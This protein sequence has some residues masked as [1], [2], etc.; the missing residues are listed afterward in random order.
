[1][2]LSIS[3]GE[4]LHLLI[5]STA[6]VGSPTAETEPSESSHPPAFIISYFSFIS[7]KYF[8]SEKGCRK[9][10][11]TEYPLGMPGCFKSFQS[12]FSTAFRIAGTI[13]DR[14]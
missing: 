1:M 10:K 2:S 12:S 7:M 13:S 11:M 8:F 9:M 4:S 3:Q 5:S 14:R 6:D